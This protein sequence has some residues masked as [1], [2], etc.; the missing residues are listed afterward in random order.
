MNNNYYKLDELA[1]KF[2]R[3]RGGTLRYIPNG[4]L[5]L[6]LYYFDDYGR[7]RRK[8]FVGRNVGECYERAN[9]FAA[10]SKGLISSSRSTIPEILHAKLADRK[11]VV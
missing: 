6:D 9:Q 7:K 11:S 4:K 2:Y 5:R 1:R 3:G 10:D 8:V